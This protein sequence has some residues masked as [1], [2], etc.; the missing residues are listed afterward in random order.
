MDSDQRSAAIAKRKGV[1]E[2]RKSRLDLSKESWQRDAH[3][4]DLRS[5]SQLDRLDIARDE[6][7]PA[8][9]RCEAEVGCHVG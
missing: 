4:V 9:D 7:R 3:A 8:R 1:L 2:M 6:L 5:S